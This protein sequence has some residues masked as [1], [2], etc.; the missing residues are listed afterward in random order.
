MQP[1]K[2]LLLSAMIVG[3][4]SAFVL[5]AYAGFGQRNVAAAAAPAP[6]DGTTKSAI[7]DATKFGRDDA[8]T[9]V[10]QLKAI[11][12]RIDRIDAKLTTWGDFIAHEGSTDAP[13]LAAVTPVWVVAVAGE[14]L[15]SSARQNYPWAVFV[16]NGTTGR[17]I[18][19]F[20]NDKTPWPAYFDALADVSR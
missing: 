1:V 4:G 15:P 14:V 17:T 20:A 3:L 10:R 9:Y 19:T 8:L 13:D 7:L 18:A 2:K 11:T 12:P 16:F 5:A 6:I